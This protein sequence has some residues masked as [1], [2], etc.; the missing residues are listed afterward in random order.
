MKSKYT[1][2]QGAGKGDRPRN[3][4]SKK[5]LEN[6]DLIK[7]SQKIKKKDVKANTKK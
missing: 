1:D 5:Y 2:N 4:F 3:C 6:Y 7:W